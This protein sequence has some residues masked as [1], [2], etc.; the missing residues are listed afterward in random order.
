MSDESKA[1]IDVQTTSGEMI[2]ADSDLLKDLA[3]GSG[4]LPYVQLFT[5]KSGAVTDGKIMPGHYGLVRDD[6]IIDLGSELDV[7]LL[8]VRARAFEKDEQGEI[9]VCYDKQDPEYA[10]IAELQANKVTGRM[11]GPEF[12]MWIPQEAC[13]AT[14]FCGSATLKREARKLGGF[15]GGKA[16]N[17][18]TKIIENRKGKWHGPVVNSCTATPDP[19]PEADAANAEV[20]RFKNPPK[21]AKGERV[22]EGDAEQV[23]R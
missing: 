10:R 20:E 18:R 19:L 16:C 7:V 22:D 14:F 11:V 3:S 6:D 13:F 9:V 1:L 5:A 21:Q 4:F 12:L 23:V 17:L 15:L 8:T 2:A